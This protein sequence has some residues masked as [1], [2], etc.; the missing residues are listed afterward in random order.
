MALVTAPPAAT[1]SVRTETCPRC[2]GEGDTVCCT[3]YSVEG[4]GGP[5]GCTCPARKRG[6]ATCELCDGSGEIV[7]DVDDEDDEEGER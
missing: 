1:S 5:R 6:Y 2:A 7:C 3:A 4:V